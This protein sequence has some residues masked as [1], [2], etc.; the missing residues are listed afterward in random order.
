V[1]IEIIHRLVYRN[2]FEL[3]AFCTFDSHLTSDRKT[4]K[5]FSHTSS[6][7][8]FEETHE[9]PMIRVRG[10]RRSPTD[11]ALYRGRSSGKVRPARSRP[12]DKVCVVQMGVNLKVSDYVCMLTI[13]MHNNKNQCVK[14]RHIWI[15]PH[16]PRYIS[17]HFTKHCKQKLTASID[18]NVID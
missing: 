1:G 10:D 8:C 6:D 12:S 3:N 11:S 9:S 18:L 15:P 5:D 2:A 17:S 13:R 7:A 16:F 4:T 14:C